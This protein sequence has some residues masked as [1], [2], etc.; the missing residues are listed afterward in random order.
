MLHFGKELVYVYPHP[1]ILQEIDFEDDRYLIC[2]RK[3]Q[4]G[5]RFR[6]WNEYCQLTRFTVKNQW[7]STQQK[8]M[9]DLQ[10]GK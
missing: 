1:K 4:S 10:F 6:L 7:S 8:G 9:K 5:L 2:Q 3:F